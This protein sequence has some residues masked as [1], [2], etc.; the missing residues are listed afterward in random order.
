MTAGQSRR[1]ITATEALSRMAMDATYMWLARALVLLVWGVTPCCWLLLVPRLAYLAA[2]HFS[3]YRADPFAAYHPAF[4]HLYPSRHPWISSAL[5]S[6]CAIEAAFSIYHAWLVRKVQAPGPR[7]LYGRRFLRGVFTKALESGLKQRHHDAVEPTRASGRF[8]PRVR[9]RAG[10]ALQRQL[11]GSDGSDHGASIASDKEARAR[12]GRLRS[13]SFVP[14]FV[15]QPLTHHDPR[16][17]R[18]QQSH[19]KWYFEAPFEHITRR[20]VH[21][22]LAWAIFGT[23]LE[24]V[25]QERQGGGGGAAP[26]VPNVESAMPSPIPASTATFG[27][28]RPSFVMEEDVK[29]SLA[30]PEEWDPTKGDRLQFIEYCRE[31]LEARQGRSYPTRSPQWKEHHDEQTSPRV[32]MM[33]LTLDPVRVS[34]RPLASYVVT[35]ALSQLVIWRA[36]R[37]GFQLRTEGRLPYMLR[38]PTGWDAKRAKE[39]P[40]IILHGLGIGLVQYY[41]LI[42]P[43]INSTTFAG[44][45]ILILLQPSISQAIFSRHFLRPFGHHEMT[46]AFRRIVAAQG[47]EAS[48]VAMLSHSYGSLV[49]SWLIKSLGSVVRKSCFV[50][51]VCFQL[52]VP[53]V[54]GNFLYKRVETP[55]EMVIRYFVAR[56]LG[57]AN[58]LCRYFDWSSNTLWADEIRNKD[59]PHLT[60]FY[61]AENDAILHAHDT[62]SYLLEMGV[63]PECI[64]F[65][66]KKAHGEI[67]VS[68]GPEFRELLRW[69][70]SPP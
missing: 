32:R 59:D 61:L 19:A 31:L 4:E 52:W 63:P 58:T 17:G 68:Q 50:D 5:F 43:L 33:R 18:F 41:S 23:T 53:Y 7:P 22:W 21:Q 45:P 64:H 42:K 56:E 66:R 49:H 47:W 57:T 48:G 30:T 34:S 13:A 65:C 44:R 60:R 29:G 24:E 35:N 62:Q 3:S 9:H 51:P 8:D 25:E 6:Y 14:A 54:C 11:S 38:M 15:D 39:P 20:D 69:L 16:A 67:F 70:A 40:L 37:L 36:K 12:L 27:G 1:T 28:P 26:H 46:A 55:M 2:M 10:N